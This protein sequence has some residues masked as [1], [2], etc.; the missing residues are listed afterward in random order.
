M[1]GLHRT[2]RMLGFAGIIMGASI[3][4]WWKL[5]ASAPEW[6]LWAGTAI[7]GASWALFVYVI[8]A[9]FLWVRKNPFG[10]AQT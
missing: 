5:D 6:T 10:S 9:R 7:L 4:V 3:V 1:R 8:V 2:K